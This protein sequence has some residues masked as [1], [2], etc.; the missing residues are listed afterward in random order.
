MRRLPVLS[1]AL[2]LA[3][4]V[5]LVAC[6]DDSDD[7]SDADDTTTTTSESTTT[8][9]AAESGSDLAV[10]F[11]RDEQ[12]ATAGR[13]AEGEDVATQA[14]EGLLAGPTDD[15]AGIGMSSEVP[16]GTELLG[17]DVADGTATIDLSSDFASG[18]G[19]QSMQARVAQVVFTLTQFPTVDD[20]TITLDGEAVE[21]IGGEGVPASGLTR[22]TF[23]SLT[24]FILVESPVPFEEVS[25]PLEVAGMSN[26]FEANVQYSL[27]DADGTVL[28]EGFTTA[29]A[30]NGTWGTFELTIDVALPDSGTGMLTMF[31]T[32]Q[33][34]GGRQDVYEVPITF[35]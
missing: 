23:E 19:S 4:A 14:I 18:G 1:L 22:A 34:T 11:L 12:V 35:G 9:A 13:G 16:E 24:P 32:N 31:Q 6:G 5:G 29:T 21:G 7:T 27:T 30:G 33:E 10:Y 20:V 28:D 25:A 8:T 17:V 3:L 15:E 2:V 26:T